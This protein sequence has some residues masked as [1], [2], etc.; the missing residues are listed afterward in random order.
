MGILVELLATKPAKPAKHALHLQFVLAL[1]WC[2][3]ATSAAP[4]NRQ[5]INRLFELILGHFIA[6]AST[7]VQFNRNAAKFDDVF[8][9]LYEL[10]KACEVQLGRSTYFPVYSNLMITCYRLYSSLNSDNDDGGGGGNNNDEFQKS[11]DF[12]AKKMNEKVQLQTD[13]NAKK[14]PPN[15]DTKRMQDK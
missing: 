2:R 12:G 14:P 8:Q 9:M 7:Y 3:T 1:Q 4:L 10:Y 13:K 11:L 5:Q 6:S 15:K